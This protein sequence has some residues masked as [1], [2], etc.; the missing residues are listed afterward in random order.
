MIFKPESTKQAQEVIFSRKNTKKIYPKI[1]FNTIPVSKADSQ[2]HLGL[3]LDSKLSFDFHIKTMLTKVNRTIG[4]LR[5]FN[6]YYLDH[7]WLS[8]T[9][10]SSDKYVDYG[11]VIFDHAFNNSFHQRLEY[12]QYNAVLAITGV[13]RGTSKKNLLRN[14]VSSSWNPEDGF[15][16]Y[17]SFT[18][19]KK[20]QKK[21][22]TIILSLS[23]NSKAIDVIFYSQLWKF[24]SH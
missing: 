21:K 18:K 19:L 17:L 11:D 3:H 8:F 20:K 7:L 2:A 15:K 24:A 9:K 14:L 22:R 12:I 6:K 10:L 16:N 4:L 1:F 13:I 5:N 23:S